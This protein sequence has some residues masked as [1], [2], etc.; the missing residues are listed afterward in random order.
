MTKYLARDAADDV[1]D[2]VLTITDR[3]TPGI[4]G[5]M[6]SYNGFLKKGKEPVPRTGPRRVRHFDNN[7][8]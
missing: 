4:L 5:Y 1:I 3:T 2:R 7:I 6:P 8:W